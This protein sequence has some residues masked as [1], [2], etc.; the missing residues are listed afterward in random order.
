MLRLSTGAALLL[1][2]TLL[3]LTTIAQTRLTIYVGPQTR[4]GFVDVDKGIL[5]SIA[6]I[7]NQLRKKPRFTVVREKDGA[8]LVL[9]V[10]Y[11]GHGRSTGAVA[12]PVGGLTAVVSSDAKVVETVLHVGTY[13]KSMVADY[14]G[15]W[16]DC[17]RAIADDVVTWVVT[18]RERLRPAFK[19]Q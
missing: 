1:I 7:Q 12:V 15:D 11:R 3:P 10:V 6:D 14:G 2:L 17:A 16:R 9:L 5:D 8:D 4:D 19:P 18:N 13:E